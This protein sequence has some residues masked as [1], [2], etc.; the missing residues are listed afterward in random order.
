MVL[1]G[2]DQRE[3]ARQVLEGKVFSRRATPDEVKLLRSF[4]SKVCKDK[5][6]EMYPR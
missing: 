2:G 3:K 1:A 4:C 5:I 6:D